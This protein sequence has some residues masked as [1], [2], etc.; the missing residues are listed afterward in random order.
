M[1]TRF[2]NC[3]APLPC[4]APAT[5]RGQLWMLLLFLLFQSALPKTVVTRPL[6]SRPSLHARCRWL[7]Y[8]D[9]DDD[10]DTVRVGVCLQLCCS[11]RSVAVAPPR[12]LLAGVIIIVHVV[13]GCLVLLRRPLLLHWTRHIPYITTWVG[14]GLP[15]RPQA[16]VSK[17]AVSLVQQYVHTYHTTQNEPE[18]FV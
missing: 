11:N 8:R 18:T 15:P 4:R 14:L 3:F 9:D 7:E 16:G 2:P 1:S 6:S 13:G 5:W 12:G 10:N 17:A